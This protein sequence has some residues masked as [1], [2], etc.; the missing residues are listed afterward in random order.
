[1]HTKITKKERKKVKFHYQ[2]FRK[3]KRKEEETEELCVKASI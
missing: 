1:M 3:M 2:R